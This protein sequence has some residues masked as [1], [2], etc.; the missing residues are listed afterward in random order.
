[1][2]RN[3]T[4]PQLWQLAYTPISLLYACLCSPLVRNGPLKGT[5]S[6]PCS[7]LVFDF[8]N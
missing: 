8:N 7:P 4:R 5:F 2:Y 1:M 6:F 3:K